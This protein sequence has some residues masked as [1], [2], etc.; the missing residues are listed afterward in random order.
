MTA[1]HR[2]AG[3]PVIGTALAAA[4]AAL[5]LRA[6]SAYC[7]DGIP[8]DGTGRPAVWRGAV[9]RPEGRVLC[10]V[11]DGHLAGLASFRTPPDAPAGTVKL[12]RFHVDPDHWRTGIGTALRT[13]C[14]EE[15]RANGLRTAVL[16]VHV[17]NRRVQAFYARLGWTPDPAH[18]PAPDNHHLYPRFAVPG[19]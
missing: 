14:V 12:F 19:E 10:A 9:T 17:D 3:S 16:D 4:I 2:T 8:E 15:W 18:P 7:P 11:R 13:A 5:H 6:R 1:T